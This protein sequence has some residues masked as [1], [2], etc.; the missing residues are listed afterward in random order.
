MRFIILY[1]SLLLLFSCKKEENIHIVALNPV[2]GEHYAGLEYVVVS[3]RTTANEEKY[4]TEAS[5]TL[6]SNGE[7]MVS[8]KQKSGRTYSIRVVE[9]ENTCYNKQI[10]QFFDSP[11]DVNGTFT[12]EFA[13][14]AYLK[15]EI[16]NVNCQGANDI[17]NIMDRYTYTEWSSWSVDVLG[18]YS[19]T[20]GDYFKVPSGKRFFKWQVNRSGV[21]EEG[22]DSI[23]F[24][25]GEYKVLTINY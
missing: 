19:N 18:C 21:L 6:N 13:E 7:A 22:I 20:T 17:F 24:N 23:T 4:R 8:I 10:T 2:T 3:S 9:P 12:F 15:Q 25:P 5:G 16:V 14:C 11:F 1:V